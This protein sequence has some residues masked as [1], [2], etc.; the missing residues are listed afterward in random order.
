[1]TKK[2]IANLKCPFCGFVQEVEVPQTGCL[3]FHKCEKCQKIIS[4][5][6]ESKECCIVCVYSDKKC[7]ASKPPYH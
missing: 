1:M 6:K 3:V 2:E 5:P 4:V 7:S